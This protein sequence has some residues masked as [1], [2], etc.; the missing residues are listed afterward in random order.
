M[1]STRRMATV[2]ITNDTL[3]HVTVDPF[4]RLVSYSLSF[5]LKQLIKFKSTLLN[6]LRALLTVPGRGHH[7]QTYSRPCKIYFSLLSLANSD[8]VFT[9]LKNWDVNP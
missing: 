3:G 1:G 9:T 4:T 5:H 2:K 8:A 6:Q 7:A